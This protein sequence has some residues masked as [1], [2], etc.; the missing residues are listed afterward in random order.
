M[1][2]SHSHLSN[3]K[4]IC[5][6]FSPG[7]FKWERGARNV[8][9]RGQK[10]LVAPLNYNLPKSTEMKTSDWSGKT[11]VLVEKI[12]STSQ[13]LHVSFKSSLEEPAPNP[14]QY[15][16]LK[17][18]VTTCIAV[19]AARLHNSL[20][21]NTPECVQESQKVLLPQ[22]NTSH[23]LHQ[24]LC[25]RWNKM[26][27][28][29]IIPL[30]WARCDPAVPRP[31]CP[32]VPATSPRSH[33][34]VI[35]GGGG[36]PASGGTHTQDEKWSKAISEKQY[37]RG[38]EL[39]IGRQYFDGVKI[40]QHVCERR[41]ICNLE[42]SQNVKWTGGSVGRICFFPPNPSLTKLY[43]SECTCSF[44]PTS[45]LFF[46]FDTCSV[47]PQPPAPGHRS[48]SLEWLQIKWAAWGHLGSAFGRR[49]QHLIQFNLTSPTTQYLSLTTGS[50][51]I[52]IYQE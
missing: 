11:S 41:A 18:N 1:W 8:G 46:Q 39:E 17:I 42:R 44:S 28:C 47:Q 50:K 38:W 21:W 25:E 13:Q 52:F 12:L 43:L 30:G 45:F 27:V 26:M 29:F 34:S 37:A 33:H 2:V 23:T 3:R 4:Y 16:V 20:L 48:A 49:K 7:W 51:L 9:N 19:H 36:P 10:L 22:V 40:N 32:S 35:D 6:V 5:R 14:T 31:L 24:S 15:I